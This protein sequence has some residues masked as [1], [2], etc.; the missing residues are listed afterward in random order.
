MIVYKYTKTHPSSLAGHMDTVRTFMRMLRRAKCTVA[1]SVGFNPHM[2]VFASPALSVGVDSLCEYM[3]VDMQLEEDIIARLNAVAPSGISITNVWQVDNI[4]LANIITKAVY[5]IHMH[6][7]SSFASDISAKPYTIQFMAK[8]QPASKE[9]SQQI[10]DVSVIDANNISVTLDCGNSTLRA[11]RIVG[12]ILNS[13][14]LQCDYLI[15][16]TDM[17]VGDISMDN[18]LKTIN[19]A[20]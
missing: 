16:K 13:N 7:I 20:S 1:Y 14:N 4:N 3:A 10:H 5:N 11:D 9:V 15:A 19:T 8:G 17:L 18:Y 2:L 6:N 12:H